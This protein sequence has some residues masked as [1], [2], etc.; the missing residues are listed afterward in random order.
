MNDN[1]PLLDFSGL[2]RF[3]SIRPAHVTPAV[4]SL[5]DDARA[6][7][8]RVASD[9]SPPSWESV[10]EPTADVLDRFDRAW[11][12]VRHLNAVVNTQELRDAYNANLPKVIE[13]FSDLSQDLRLY[14]RYRALRESAAFASLDAAQ[15]KLVDNEIRDFKLGGAAL[16]DAGKERLKSIHAELGEVTTRFEEN[17]L[18]A[19]NAWGHYG[20]DEA[21][22]AGLPA[23]VVAAARAA[24]Q[25]EGRSGWKLTL[26]MPCYLP[27]MQYAD[28]RNLRRLMHEAYST[29]ASDLGS[30]PEWDNGPLILRILALRHEA[31]QL[32]GYRNYAEV[33]LVP[34]MAQHPEEVIAFLRDLA[35]RAKPFAKRDYDEL[36]DFASGTLGLA[37]LEPWDLAYAS[38]KLKASRY[39]Y[40]EQEVRQYLPEDRVLAGLFRVVETIY[41][42]SIVASRAEVW[43]PDVRFFTIHDRS[44]ALVGEFYFDLYARENKQGGAWMD[45]AINRRR[46][47]GNVQHPVAYLT[48]NL[49]AP[50]GGKPATF[51]H[52]EVITIF[53]EFGHGLHQLLTRI[54]IP[55]ISGLQGVEWDAVELP[56]QFMENFVWE[57][58]VLSHMTQHVDTGEALPRDLF[59]RMLAARN[60]ESGLATVRQ[61]EMGLFDMRVHIEYESRAG[62]V[63]RPQDILA[64][65]R[66]EVAIVPRAPYD[67]F[68]ESFSH[69]F[70]GGYAAGYYSYKWAEVL[71]AD[72]FSLFE[73]RGVLSSEVGARF[74]DEVLARGGSRPAIESFVAFRGRPPQLDALLRHNGMIESA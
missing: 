4:D 53:H 19:T 69:V 62:D 6:T 70:A 46:V 48:C 11:G 12:A 1:N 49:S 34:K 28:D 30:S 60:F 63:Q 36:R 29:R 27:V 14:A 35:R 5:L 15:R 25:A 61:L 56:S 59:D 20:D 38:E 74:R 44:G 43:H 41:G 67:R 54:E 58:D 22:L 66:R 16:D 23:D 73:E 17:L 3:E 64:E 24:A 9:A 26:R 8:A 7:I 50:V 10:V 31:A 65:V 55:G 71:S 72:A 57:W 52:Q 47:Q 33:S 32:L 40:N 39:A 13:F 18:D 21:A 68:M 2:P 37:T 45:D 42:V 51:T